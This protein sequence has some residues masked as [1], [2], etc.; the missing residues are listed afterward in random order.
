LSLQNHIHPNSK[1]RMTFNERLADR[2]RESLVQLSD[3]E[4]KHMFGGVC[5]MVNGK[6]C[7]ELL[8]TN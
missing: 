1:N 6:M 3:V 7:A 8:K 4:E 2:I 5:F